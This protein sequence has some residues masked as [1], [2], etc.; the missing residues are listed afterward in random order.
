[1]TV[2]VACLY[3]SPPWERGWG[4]GDGFRRPSAVVVAVLSVRLPVP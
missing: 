1:M 3:L 4:E 2:A